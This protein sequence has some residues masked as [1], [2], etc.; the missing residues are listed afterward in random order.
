MTPGRVSTS[1]DFAAHAT[2]CVEAVHEGRPLAQFVQI[3]LKGVL[4]C[5]R[6]REAWITQDGLELWAVDMLGPLRG[7]CS[8]PYKQVRQCSGL[9]GLCAC[10]GESGA[11]AC[12]AA[13]TARTGARFDGGHG[14]GFSQAG[15]VAPPESLNFENLPV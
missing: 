12:G 5:A 9:D 2:R 1:Y 6:L 11:S 14:G 10:S 15:V 13:Q 7:R 3:K 8:V 4:I